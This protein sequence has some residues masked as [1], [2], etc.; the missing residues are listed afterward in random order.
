VLVEPLRRGTLAGSA[1][2]TTTSVDADPGNNSAA[3][4]TTVSR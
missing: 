1:S 4:T 3:T 2:V